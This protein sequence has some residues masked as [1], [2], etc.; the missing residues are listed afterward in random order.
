MN[1]VIQ[2]LTGFTV[3]RE[4]IVQNGTIPVFNGPGSPNMTGL[5]YQEVPV[6]DPKTISVNV[7]DSITLYVK[8]IHANSTL[9][10]S[11]ATGH[12]LEFDAFQILDTNIPWGATHTYQFKATS[13]TT[14]QFQCAQVC[15][16]K[17]GDMKGNYSAGCGA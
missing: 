1:A 17:H 14:G 8:S 7:G 3:V 4:L 6:K 11:S 2:D 9:E 5:R 15:S 12:G 13:E 10:L 16:G